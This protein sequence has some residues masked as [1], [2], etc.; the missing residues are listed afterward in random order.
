MRRPITLLPNPAARSFTAALTRALLAL[1]LG[2]CATPTEVV[3]PPKPAGPVDRRGGARWSAT[4]SGDK[5]TLEP[6]SAISYRPGRPDQEPFDITVLHAVIGAPTLSQQSR[7]LAAATPTAGA[8][9]TEGGPPRSVLTLVDIDE[10]RALAER[11][12][13]SEGDPRLPSFS[14]DGRWLTYVADA[15]GLPCLFVL[16]LDQ[17]EGSPPIQLTNRG[18]SRA[19]G[20]PLPTG[21]QPPPIRNPKVLGGLVEG[22]K[23][24]YD[25]DD[26]PHA[27]DLPP[28]L[29]P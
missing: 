1:A 6:S 3:A 22:W 12:I 29:T 23:I 14:V 20:A 28:A 15:N 26:G 21:Y 9:R 25:A 7:R 17:G 10:T 16:D 11:V 13:V 19:E 18:L 27:L 5:L 8:P 2:G 4:L 24:N